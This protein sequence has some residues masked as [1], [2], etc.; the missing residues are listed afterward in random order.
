MYW[1][2]GMMP[3]EQGKM[4]NL[5]VRKGIYF[6]VFF[7]IILLLYI[8][9]IVPLYNAMNAQEIGQSLFDLR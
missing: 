1:D 4:T 6:T 8:H 5:H 2:F 3:L 7:S 9:I